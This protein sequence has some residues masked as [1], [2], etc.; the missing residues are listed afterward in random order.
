MEHDEQ[1]ELISGLFKDLGITSIVDGEGLRDPVDK[2]LTPGLLSLP[3]DHF[4]AVGLDAAI[5]AGLSNCWDF[6]LRVLEQ[7]LSLNDDRL[8]VKLLQFRCL[9]ELARYGEALALGQAVR[10]PPEQMIHV[11]YL[12][13][14][15]YDGLGMSDLAAARFQAVKKQNPDYR[16]VAEKSKPE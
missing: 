15:T 5:V 4:L 7:L 12:M 8:S 13:G 2:L 10:W 11:N 6:S 1:D 14:L 3:R 16:G 9:T